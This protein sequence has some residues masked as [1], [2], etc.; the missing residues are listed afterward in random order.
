M[1]ATT[2][3][4]PNCSYKWSGLYPQDEYHNCADI[5]A[6][7][8]VAKVFENSDLC[9]DCDH[10]IWGPGGPDPCECKILNGDRDYDD[11]PGYEPGDSA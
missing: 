4:C 10:F 2:W 11:C 3:S 7:D 5:I 9:N 6:Y 1:S 8:K